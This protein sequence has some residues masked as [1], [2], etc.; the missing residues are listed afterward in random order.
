M[1]PVSTGF[2]WMTNTRLIGL[3]DNDADDS[4]SATFKLV[5]ISAKMQDVVIFKLYDGT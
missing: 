5:S 3:V 4:I 2:V 1:R